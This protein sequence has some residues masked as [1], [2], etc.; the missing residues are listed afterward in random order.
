MENLNIFLLSLVSGW[1]YLLFLKR[2]DRHSGSKIQ[3]P[4]LLYFLGAGVVSALLAILVGEFLGGF[5][6]LGRPKSGL[7][8]ILP[9]WWLTA[10]SE[11]F[12]KYACFALLAL[13][14]R[15]IK[16][17]QDGSLQGAATGLG[18]ALL[19]N[20]IYGFAGG[21]PLLLLRI[22][23]SLPGH[24]IFG[25]V[26]GGYHG[27][28][29]YQ[30]GGRLR[31]RSTVMLALVPAMFAHAAFNSLVTL[32]APL[33]VDLS[34][35]LLML[36]FGVFLF[37]QLKSL[38]PY[39]SQLILTDWEQTVPLLEHALAVDPDAYLL[40]QRLSAYL[41]F[42]GEPETALAHLN[43][44]D[45]L[46]FGDPW[47]AFYRSAALSRLGQTSEAT[48]YINSFQGSVGAKSAGKASDLFQRLVKSPSALP[49]E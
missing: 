8:A 1:L 13:L 32:G 31:H 16:E 17:P 29:V 22:F 19:E 48:R 12:S 46:K 26:W 30:G 23:V 27:Y 47:T 11:E 21:S 14:L 28:E 43:R 44:V 4:V 40:R 6:S 36:A 15:S 33:A 9:E 42:L 39:Q 7:A 18:F 41:I 5:V 35:E 34:V 10:P 2:L 38:S 24:L 49:K 25:A 37:L 45:D 20:V 3:G